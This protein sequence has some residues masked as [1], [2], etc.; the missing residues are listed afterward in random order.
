[1]ASELHIRGVLRIIQRQFFL[2]LKENICCDPSL[3]PSQRD[4]SNDGSQNMLLWRI[5]EIWIIIPKLSLLPF[6][7]WST[8]MV[9]VNIEE[10]DHSPPL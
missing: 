8:E 4:G 3:E 9:C 2:F 5:S 6:L 10:L 1:M 7:I